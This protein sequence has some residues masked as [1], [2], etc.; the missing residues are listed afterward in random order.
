MDPSTHQAAHQQRGGR[1][2]N[3]FNCSLLKRSHS[4]VPLA[5]FHPSAPCCIRCRLKDRSEKTVTQ[6]QY[7]MLTMT[8][9]VRCLAPA[10]G[11]ALRSK[12]RS[13]CGCSLLCGW[14]A[15]SAARSR[16][17]TRLYLRTDAPSSSML[18][19]PR[20]GAALAAPF[21]AQHEHRSDVRQG[22]LSA[23]THLRPLI[24]PHIFLS[25][26]SFR[27]APGSETRLCTEAHIPHWRW[28]G[29][30]RQHCR[31]KARKLLIVHL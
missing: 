16:M 17:R 14:R 10:A 7:S 5:L 12:V 23:H 15:R 25:W 8:R 21:P 13:G 28:M 3:K 18:R 6:N 26:A 4:P 1:Q 30:P 24:G 11:P 29:H 9:L 27:F 31:P 19:A 20:A 22:Q 2:C